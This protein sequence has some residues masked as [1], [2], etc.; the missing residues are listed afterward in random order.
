[1][2]GK[3]TLITPPDIWE[4]ENTGILFINLSDQDQENIS[5]WLSTSEV[6]ENLN[7]YL[8]DGQPD[9]SWLFHAMNVCHFKYINLNGLNNVTQSLSGYFLGKNNFFYS[10]TDENIAAIYSHIN[11]NRIDRIESFLER[12]FK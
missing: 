5:K 12:I 10:T 7:L 6:S 4:N 11:G 1:M 2:N 9:M 3:L 8:Y